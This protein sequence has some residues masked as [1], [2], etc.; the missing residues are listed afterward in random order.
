MRS[1]LIVFLFS[2]SFFRSKRGNFFFFLFCFSRR[3]RTLFACLGE[4]E[5]ELSFDPNQIITNGERI[6]M[7]KIIV[8]PAPSLP[9]HFSPS[10]SHH[11]LP[12]FPSS[13][14][15]Y[16]RFPNDGFFF[17]FFTFSSTISRTRLVG[18]NAQR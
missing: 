8:N 2:A 1:M 3:V 5:G 7:K 9:P 16:R 13:P 4:N 12:P 17:S 15:I 10:L 6:S 11:Y 14:L 18:R